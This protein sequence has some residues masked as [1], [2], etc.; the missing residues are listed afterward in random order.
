MD[1]KVVVYCSSKADLPREI[2]AGA[3]LIGTAIGRGGDTLV[4]GGVN[5]GLMHTV[6]HAAAEAGANVVG[7]VPKMF[8]HR[9]DPLCTAI[10]EAR[11]LND[12]KAIMIS[13]ADIFVV[14]PGGIG[15]IDEWISTISHIL[16]SERSVPTRDTADR[17]AANA[18]RPILVWNHAG[19]YDLLIQAL[20]ESDDSEF[21]QRRNA[22]RSLIFNSAEE[23]ES[24]LRD[25]SMK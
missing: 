15:T 3:E 8:N 14:L 1:K 6:A 24:A 17:R 4:Y 9:V 10:I 19:M 22:S 12:R 13:Q 18:D 21:G 16:A 2:V 7:V 23:L 5:A 20:Q 25:I 11:D